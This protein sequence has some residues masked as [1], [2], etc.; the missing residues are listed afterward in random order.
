MKRHVSP[1]IPG[2]T[3]WEQTPFHGVEE[4]GRPYFRPSAW[5]GFAGLPRKGL[6]QRDG[7]YPFWEECVPG[8]W[9]PSWKPSSQASTCM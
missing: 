9:C 3:A 5:L 4:E 7:F 6:Y 8:S 2:Q 1:Q